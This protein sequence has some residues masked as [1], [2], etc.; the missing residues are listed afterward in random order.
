[1]ILAFRPVTW[2]TIEKAAELTGRSEKALYSLMDR[3]LLVE[4]THWK[5]SPDNRK[6]INLEEYDKWVA[7]SNSRGS[8]RG[9]RP[10]SSASSGMA[11]GSEKAL[12]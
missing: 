1:M 7:K 2:V 9:R 11:S 12:G 4:G 8:T 6:H 5:W 10:S 3:G